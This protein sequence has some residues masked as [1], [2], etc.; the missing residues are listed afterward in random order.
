MLN[1]RDVEHLLD[2][3]LDGELPA[4]L[5][6]EVHAHLLQCLVCRQRIGLLQAV[7]DVVHAD[8]DHP[9]PSP[10]FTDRLLAAVAA[11][12]SG[13]P[14]ANWT[15][16]ILL[17]GT[18]V[19]SA[20]AALLLVVALTHS[21]RPAPV[22]L[23]TQEKGLTDA[24]AQAGN[25]TRQAIQQFRGTVESLGLL[26]QQALQQAN[27]ALLSDLTRAAADQTQPVSTATALPFMGQL[28]IPLSDLLELP[29]D[30]SG[31]DQPLE[32]PAEE[33]DLI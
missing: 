20:A 15:R 17:F 4:S 22:V 10:E 27:Q 21:Q 25:Q 23:G 6:A 11:G 5:Q 28:L 8:R 31:S 16:R 30:R 24:L 29:L 12:K 9:S 32:P 18:A 3:Y 14:R 13:P 2:A 7:A 26:G 19:T 1:C 33:L